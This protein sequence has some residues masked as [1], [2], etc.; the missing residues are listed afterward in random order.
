MPGPSVFLRDFWYLALTGAELPAGRFVRR[1][2]LGEPLLIGRAR[3]G[4][5]FAWRDI[6]P[7]RGMPLSYGTFD[8]CEVSCSYHGWRFGPDGQCTAIPS[9]AAGQT[10]INLDRIRVQSFPCR[11]SQGLVWVFVPERTDPAHAAE[12]PPVPLMPGPGDASPRVAISM[13]FPCGADHAAYGLMDP[14]HA[15]FVH[16]SWWWKKNAGRLRE[17]TKHFEPA[18]LGWRMARHRLPGEH[19][20]YRLLGREVTTEITYSLPGLRI[21]H[22]EGDRHSAVGL[23]AITPVTETETIVHQCMFW[24]PGWLGPLKPVARHLMRMFLGQDRDVVAKQQEGL[25]YGPNLMLIDDADTQARW[26]T[27]VKREFLRARDEGRPFANPVKA[28]TLRWRS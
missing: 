5:V 24:T 11:E 10:G 14:T 15:A 19:R 17:K 9:L 3:D 20:L 8:G 7:H 18:P 28:R 1:K 23:T 13:P 21:E 27:Q 26:Y 12:L 4:A 22:I 25:A 2:I 16:T 6:C